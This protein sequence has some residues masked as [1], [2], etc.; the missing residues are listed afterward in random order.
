M[1]KWADN[2]GEDGIQQWWRDEN[3]E[4]MDGLPTGLLE[5]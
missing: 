5:S 1:D 2:K 3:Q 4:S